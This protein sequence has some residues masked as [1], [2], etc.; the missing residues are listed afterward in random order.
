MYEYDGDQYTLQEL[1]DSARAQNLDFDVFMK[2]MRSRG[3]TE[4]RE[5]QESLYGPDV[6]PVVGFAVD[7][8]TTIPQGGL[9]A[10]GGIVNYLEAGE[11]TIRNYLY[12]DL[13]DEEKQAKFDELEQ[14]GFS[15]LS[16]GDDNVFRNAGKFFDQFDAKADQSITEDIADG[17]YAQAGARAVV[18]GIESWPSI[19]AAYMGAPAM[20]ALGVSYAG[21]KFE[22]EL[23]KDPQANLNQLL[24][25]AT[26][27]GAIE[28]G[29]EM[30]TRGL[31]KYAG[32]IGNQAGATAAKK[33][34]QGGML[35]LS[36]NLAGG[37]VFEGASE[38]AT[39]VANNIWDSMTIEGREMPT[40]AQMKYQLGDAFLVG[41]LVG[42]TISGIGEIKS[43]GQASVDNATI[44]LMPLEEKKQFQ[45]SI[46]NL[47]N[48]YRDRRKAKTDDAREIIDE[49]IIRET[50]VA[51]KIKND[52]QSFLENLSSKNIKQYA[53]NVIEINKLKSQ[54][55]DNSDNK[56]I[57]RV[58]SEKIKTLNTTN[59]NLLEA[60]KTDL[61]EQ[62]FKNIQDIAVELEKAGG[63]KINVLKGNT[64]DFEKFSAE[65]GVTEEFDYS[66]RYG[67]M[68]PVE[69]ADGNITSLDIFIN[70]ETVLRDGKVNTSAH[71][72]LHAAVFATLKQDIEAGEVLGDAVLRALT[73]NKATLR[74]GSDFNER[75][76]SYSKE[77][78]AGEEII[79][80]TSEAIINKEINLNEGFIGGLKDAFRRFGQKYLNFDMKFDTDQDI[81]NFVKDYSR[82]IKDP[83]KLNKALI[84]VA[85]QGAKGRLAPQQVT[86][87]PKLAVSKE[88]SDNVQRIYE[89]QGARGAFEIINEFKPIVNRIVDK[90][91]DAPNFDRQLLTDEIETGQRGILD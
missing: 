9:K 50:Q 78:G 85:A 68:L 56:T 89:D 73:A 22:E 44:T 31:L 60:S 49:E 53:N 40:L 39:E 8:L 14:G 47:E 45:Q 54:I 82:A 26:G 69:D 34:L 36:K 87:D 33:I 46:S 83:S 55:K 3:L 7:V 23:E 57:Q 51:Q 24:L 30:A 88:A 64:K 81:L 15:L 19:A 43:K 77:E 1:Q 52:T 76:N 17:N 79:P 67:G 38:A 70:E 18:T 37:F 80:L 20:L 5:Q 29:F 91:K 48:L 66:R 21:N 16:E 12:K 61:A 28:A 11:R 10:V 4:K 27:T 65:R 86:P 71:E 84:K 58:N 25:N 75:I 42:G 59:V 90:R 63:K 13:N 35:E 2:N 41:G 62:Q 72:F 6:D 32:V 74:E